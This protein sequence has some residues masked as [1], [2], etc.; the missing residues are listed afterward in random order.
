MSAKKQVNVVELKL[1]QM[2]DRWAKQISKFIEK[3]DFMSDKILPLVLTNEEA[4]LRNERAGGMA[5]IDLSKKNERKIYDL[6]CDVFSRLT[7]P[8]LVSVQP[9]ESP[10]CLVFFMNRKKEGLENPN[11][12]LPQF[13]ISVETIPVSAKSI[14]LNTSCLFGKTNKDETDDLDLLI[15]HGL[16]RKETDIYIYN[17]TIKSIANEIDRYIITELIGGISEKSDLVEDVSAYLPGNGTFALG[18][19]ANK[20]FRSCFSAPDWII[21]SPEYVELIIGKKLR[22]RDGIFL[23]GNVS[24]VDIW[25]D[26]FFPHAALIGS[27][28]KSIAGCLD[29]G[30]IWSPYIPLVFLPSVLD[31]NSSPTAELYPRSY[32]RHAVTIANPGRFMLLTDKNTAERL[33]TK[34][35]TEK[36]KPVQLS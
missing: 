14:R 8:K 28:S 7:M 36:I 3:P 19:A 20:L 26:V 24:G 6:I 1:K 35:I 2:K 30:C 9:M 15:P 4:Y 32:M 22:L 34:R 23:A 17:E 13:N 16:S 18:D 11:T 25:C 29:N 10:V 12:S 33:A 27:S 21:G 31:P 5:N